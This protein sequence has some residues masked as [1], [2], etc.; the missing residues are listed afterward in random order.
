MEAPKKGKWKSS[1]LVCMPEIQKQIIKE[2]HEEL[3]VL[4][5]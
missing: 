2:C 1:T 3:W 5:H 4:G